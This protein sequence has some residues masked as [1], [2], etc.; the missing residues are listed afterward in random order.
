LS[1]NDNCKVDLKFYSK[2]QCL[3]SCGLLQFTVMN[4]DSS[5]E[6]V[7][8]D[9]SANHTKIYQGNISQLNIKAEI[10]ICA[11]IYLVQKIVKLK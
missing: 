3:L 10:N 1:C 2:D 5:V 7:M 8:Y 11:T 6:I 9:S 4:D